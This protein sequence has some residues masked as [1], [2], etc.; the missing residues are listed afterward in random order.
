MM[1]WKLLAG[2]VCAIAVT[3]TFGV[4]DASMRY[5][6]KSRASN[7]DDH[8][9]SWKD[10]KGNEFNVSLFGSGTVGRRTIRHPSLRRIERNGEL[11]LGAGISYFFSRYVGVEGYAYSEDTHRHFVDNVDGNLILRLPI[12]HS[13]LALYG[14]GGGGRQFDPV[15]QWTLHAGG[16]VEWRFV[17]HVGVFADAQ[18][19]WAD[20]TR[21]YGLGR[22]GLRIGF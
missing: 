2:T 10:Y 18:Y 9:H 17:E 4:D 22:V 3:A 13:G 12:G 15:I 11:G 5:D 6:D 19:V 8:S 21:D 7:D 14:L 16:G 1:N 20:E